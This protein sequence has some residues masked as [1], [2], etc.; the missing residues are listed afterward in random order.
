LDDVRPP[1]ILGITSTRRDLFAQYQPLYRVEFPNQ[2]FIS[3]AERRRNG[4]AKGDRER[5]TGAR[6]RREKEEKK[7]EVRQCF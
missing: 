7:E 5:R 6:E 4:K 3:V 1:N 2:I